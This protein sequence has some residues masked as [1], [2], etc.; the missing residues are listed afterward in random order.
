MC[1]Y[2]YIY[3]QGFALCVSVCSR[4]CTQI[5]HVCVY[6]FTCTH[7]G[8]VCVCMRVYICYMCGY[9]FTYSHR[10]FMCDLQH[11]YI[12]LSSPRGG[13]IVSKCHK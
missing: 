9:I 7:T 4:V 11:V 1:A 10:V 8:S 13:V 5:I 12:R 6:M 3:G 2:V